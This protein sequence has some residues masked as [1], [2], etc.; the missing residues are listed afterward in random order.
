MK[1]CSSCCLIAQ[2]NG[3]KS[4]SGFSRT[5]RTLLP[6]R[7]R[8]SDFCL[9]SLRNVAGEVRKRAE[10]CLESPELP[11]IYRQ[12][13]DHLRK[14]EA[15]SVLVSKILRTK[16]SEICA[17]SGDCTSG[18]GWF[19]ICPRIDIEDL[20]TCLPFVRASRDGKGILDYGSIL[21]QYIPLTLQ[22]YGAPLGTSQIASTIVSRISPPLINFSVTLQ[23]GDGT[24]PKRYP[25]ITFISPEEFLAERIAG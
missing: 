6:T 13:A 7:R 2:K 20:R 1:R 9:E 21:P 8:R 19:T 16:T 3:W 12:V 23:D 22:Q 14:L 17:N 25:D 5:R 18:V 15:A 10:A 24:E 4:G 11:R